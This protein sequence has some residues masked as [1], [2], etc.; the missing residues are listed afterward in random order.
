MVDSSRSPILCMTFLLPLPINLLSH[1]VLNRKRV[2]QPERSRTRTAKDYFQGSSLGRLFKA[3]LASQV[4]TRIGL[5]IMSLRRPNLE[6]LIMLYLLELT[7]IQCLWDLFVNP[8]PPPP[9]H[10]LSAADFTDQVI[11]H[12]VLM[13]M[14][15]ARL[16]SWKCY[17]NSRTLKCKW[18]SGFRCTGTGKGG[19]ANLEHKSN[20]AIRFGWWSA[21][22]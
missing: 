5:R 1:A 11:I 15:V 8:P 3:R 14:E 18:R 21:E 2:D 12:R 4:S 22:E 9:A 13:T 6:T 7:A 10:Y 16:D 19:E 20:N 17:W